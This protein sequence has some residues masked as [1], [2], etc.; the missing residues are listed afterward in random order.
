MTP[1][2][3]ANDFQSIENHIYPKFIVMK[4]TTIEAPLIGV[5]ALYIRFFLQ[6][7]AA[8]KKLA[9][10]FVSYYKK[11]HEFGDRSK[12]P[13]GCQWR[14][15]AVDFDKKK[16][17]II[18]FKVILHWGGRDQEWVIRLWDTEIIKDPKITGQ[19]LETKELS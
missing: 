16:N 2:Y 10:D 18:R 1:Q 14:Y 19:T 8:N 3:T 5:L 6:P 4:K 12:M 11:R 7:I 15:V 17:T 9:R 13:E